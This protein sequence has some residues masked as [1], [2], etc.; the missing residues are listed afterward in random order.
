MQSAPPEIDVP[1]NPS[2]IGRRVH[3]I[4]NSSSG[5]S[6]LAARLAKALD[7][8]FVELDALNWLPGWVGLNETDPDELERRFRHATR[9]DAWVVAGSYAGYSQRS[10]WARLETVIW[11]DLPM[12]VLLKRVFI[13]SWRRARSREL[14]WG[15]NVEGFWQHFMVWRKEKS[16]IYWIVTQHARKRRQMLSWMADPRWAHVRFVRLVSAG[17][18]DGFADAVEAVLSACA[19]ACPGAAAGAA[20]E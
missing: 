10:F 14:L 11:L 6:T 5:K 18:A 20:V 7:A 16:L 17:E 8:K 19:T 13:R 12:R 9:G 1:A 3:V 2:P 4:G 15:T